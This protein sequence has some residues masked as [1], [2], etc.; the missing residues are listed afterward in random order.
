MHPCK[1]WLWAVFESEKE[2]DRDNE[3][4]NMPA[5]HFNYNLYQKRPKKS[6]KPKNVSS[7]TSEGTLACMLTWHAWKCAV[8]KCFFAIAWV[9]SA[10]ELQTI[11]NAFLLLSP[12]NWYATRLFKSG[13]VS[14]C[15]W[16]MRVCM[17]SH[18]HV[19]T[20]FI[21][22]PAWTTRAGMTRIITGAVNWQVPWSICADKQTFGPVTNKGIKRYLGNFY[23]VKN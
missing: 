13:H 3:T 8:L 6:A 14:T 18:A 10:I 20:I 16:H 22:L 23:L 5:L 21:V 7:Y 12:I 2:L 11:F 15:M 1:I 19:C 4:W 17:W 9:G